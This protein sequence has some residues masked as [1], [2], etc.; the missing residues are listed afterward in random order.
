MELNIHEAIKD[1]VVSPPHVYFKLKETLEDPRSSFKEFSAIILNDPALSA[2]LLKIVNSP[3]YGLENEIDTISDALGVIGTEQLAQLVL[4]TSVTAKFSGMPQD[5]MS[6]DQF[7]KHSIAC[8]VTAKI[9]AAWHGERNLESYYLAGMLHD[10]GSLIIYKKFP[11]EAEKILSRCNKNEEHLFDVELEIF[12][13]SH[14]RV[15]GELLKGWG[16]PS[17]LYEPVFFH[18]RPSKAKDNP[19]ITK[20]VHVADSVVDEMK[21]GCSGEVIANPVE[22]KVLQELGFSEL[23]SEKFEEEIK[24]QYDTALAIFL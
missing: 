24:D 22:S 17:L 5:L 15:G 13:S 9:I 21:L 20:I 16:L 18:H 1:W 4:A 10:I 6:M 19:L 8:G 3:F 2:R 11:S 23:P 14:A 12:G 7:W